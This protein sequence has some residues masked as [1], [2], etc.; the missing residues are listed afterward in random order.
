[1]RCPS[2]REEEMPD[3]F[4][5]NFIVNV[6]TDRNFVGQTNKARGQVY[7]CKRGFCNM[8]GRLDKAFGT[9][10]SAV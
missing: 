10:P 9:Q 1:M 4:V 8:L 5:L 3:R 7:E 6:L 2:R